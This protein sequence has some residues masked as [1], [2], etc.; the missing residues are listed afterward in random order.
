MSWENVTATVST[1]LT[2]KNSNPEQQ[3]KSSLISNIPEIPVETNS[4]NQL[5]E[6]YLKAHISNDK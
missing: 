4:S 5:L 3:A 6:P 1:N 2:A